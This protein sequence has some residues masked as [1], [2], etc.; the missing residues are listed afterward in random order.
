MNIVVLKGNLARDPE[1]KVVNTGANR[2]SS[3]VSLTIAVN[4]YF[5]KSNGEQSKETTFIPC[6]AWDT[7]AE[8]IAKYCSKG[9]EL[10]IEGSIK[11]DR[12][13]TAEGQKR[14]KLKIRIN[15]FELPRKPKDRV[16]NNEQV[17]NA[18]NVENVDEND[19]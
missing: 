9:D 7:G 5:K 12:W 8:T 19:F 6:E 14:S 2:Q 18:E 4:R 11:E 13:E 16:V 10:L 1:I 15:N 17:E 3:V